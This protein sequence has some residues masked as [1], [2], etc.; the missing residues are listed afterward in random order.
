MLEGWPLTELGDVN[1]EGPRP[2]ILISDM[3][4]IEEMGF[5][6]ERRMRGIWAGG[7]EGGVGRVFFVGL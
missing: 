6:G 3:V 1:S 5:E 7:N 2:T 4:E